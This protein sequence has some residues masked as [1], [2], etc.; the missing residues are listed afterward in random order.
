MRVMPCVSCHVVLT[1]SRPVSLSTAGRGL[2]T[3]AVREVCGLA[4]NGYGL[5]T[6]RAA[7]TVDNAASRAVLSRAGFTLTGTTRLSGRPGL[8]FL[9]NLA[10]FS[11]A[12][13]RQ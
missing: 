12:R 7:T 5:T 8:T 1:R 10:D 9:R 2:A 13:V 6:L 3:S 11:A 4:V